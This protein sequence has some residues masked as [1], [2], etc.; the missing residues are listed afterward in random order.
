MQR[1]GERG[2]AARG[3]AGK[4]TWGQGANTRGSEAQRL[5]GP[6]R[7]VQMCKCGFAACKGAKVE[8]ESIEY[9]VLS[10]GRGKETGDGW[11]PRASGV[12][13]SAVRPSGAG[14]RIP[15]AEG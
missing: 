6:G 7:E 14:T 8:Y 5:G 1:K 11:R 15:V 9:G 2:E 3:Q 10:I 4:L 12:Q 13:E